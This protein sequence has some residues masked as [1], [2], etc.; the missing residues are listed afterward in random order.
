M[1]NGV[2]SYPALF[3][4]INSYRLKNGAPRATSD[5]PIGCIILEQPFFL[6]ERDWI[7]IPIDYHLNLVQGKA[8]TVESESGSA[9]QAWGPPMNG[10]LRNALTN[11]WLASRTAVRLIGPV[12]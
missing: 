1:K 4:A 6:P 8:F 11:P 7:D 10:A 12:I 2:S 9:L 3:D 5:T